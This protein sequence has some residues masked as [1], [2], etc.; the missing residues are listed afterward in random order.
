VSSDAAYLTLSLA[1]AVT[2]VAAAIGGAR[3]TRRLSAATR[4]N[5]ARGVAIAA[6]GMLT[7]LIGGVALNA[8]KGTTGDLFFQRSHFFVFYLGFGLVF[9]GIHSFAAGSLNVDAREP[10]G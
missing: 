4:R 2:L 1:M 9:Y 6:G 7:V 5:A 8:L 10:Q 3:A